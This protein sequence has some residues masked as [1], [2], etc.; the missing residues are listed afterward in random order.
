M[1]FGSPKESDVRLTFLNVSEAVAFADQKVG[2][3]PGQANAQI[4]SR[5]QRKCAPC[6]GN[7]S[8]VSAITQSR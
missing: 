5:P 3:F 4:Y 2:P 7:G 8:T 6:A 1:N